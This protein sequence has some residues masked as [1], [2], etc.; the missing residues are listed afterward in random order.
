MSKRNLHI[1]A[2]IAVL[3]AFSVS[4]AGGMIVSVIV[5]AIYL[6]S[7]RVHPRMRHRRCRGTGEHRGSVFTWTHRRCPGCA[8]GPYHPVGGGAVGERSHPARGQA[9]EGSQ[10]EGQEQ[11]H[12]KLSARRGAYRRDS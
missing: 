7:L 1:T 2:A 4:I 5:A 6:S 3:V 9:R 8:G 11:P 12:L 10:G